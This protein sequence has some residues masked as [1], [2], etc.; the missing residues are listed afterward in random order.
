[1]DASW[2]FQYEPEAKHQSLQWT[3]KSSPRPKKFCLQKSEIK[4]MLI[5][6][7]DKQGVIQEEFVSEQQRVNSAFYVEVIGGLLK[8]ISRVRPQF[9]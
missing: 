2:L 9:E 3:S 7:F 8:R 4:T 6:F 5:T 1:V